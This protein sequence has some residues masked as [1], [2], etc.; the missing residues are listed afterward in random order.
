MSRFYQLLH[1]NQC[2]L[3]K[4]VYLEFFVITKIMLVRQALAFMM[5]LVSKFGDQETYL[6]ISLLYVLEC[7]DITAHDLPRAIKSWALMPLSLP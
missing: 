3:K 6:W 4:S 7:H 1:R 5:K 2:T